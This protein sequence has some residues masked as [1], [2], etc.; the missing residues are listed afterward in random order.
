MR[1]PGDL[2]PPPIRR[3]GRTTIAVGCPRTCAHIDAGRVLEVPF[4]GARRHSRLGIAAYWR[5]VRP[6]G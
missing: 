4:R 2:Q 6:I 1:D 3:S 5:R